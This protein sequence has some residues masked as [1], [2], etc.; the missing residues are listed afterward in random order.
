MV[1]N[2]DQ[3]VIVLSEKEQIIQLLKGF[4][5]FK[6]EA[7]IIINGL[8]GQVLALQKENRSLK[9]R[10]AKYENPKNSGNGSAPR[11]KTLFEK[12]KV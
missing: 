10:L 4:G 1:P 5:P 12:P 3:T 6:K 11:L 8:K 7:E 9:E 2:F